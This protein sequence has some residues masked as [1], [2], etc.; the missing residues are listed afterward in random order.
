[1][2]EA[3]RKIIERG[4]GIVAGGA[5]NV[6]YFATDEALKL[7]PTANKI[8]IFLPVDLDLYAAHYRKRATEGVITSEQADAL[9]AQLESLRA[10]NPATLIENSQNTVVDTKTYYER[11]T[12]VTNASDALVGFQINESKG[13]EDTVKKTI[14]QGK[15][16]YL[17]KFIIE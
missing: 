11:N 16:V 3:V 5:L 15:L 7:N 13:V 14:K 12:D 2:R 8:K 10:A 9:I 1:M 17:K 4:D 6:D